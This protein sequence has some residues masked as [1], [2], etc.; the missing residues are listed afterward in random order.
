MA[1]DAVLLMALGGPGSMDEV[2]P[3]VESVLG[4]RP[5]PPHRIDE[6][7][8]HYEAVGGRS[9]L[10][11]WTRAQARALEDRL[12]VDG[13]TVPVVVGMRCWSPWLADTV[14]E[15]VA[16]RAKRVVTILMS[17]FRDAFT[18]GQYQASLARAA[19]EASA[20]D[21]VFQEV[22]GWHDHPLYTE[23]M[24]DRVN[25][26]AEVAQGID[27]AVTP[28][29]F[30][31]HS[32]PLNAPGVQ[33]HVAAVR[34]TAR[35]VAERLAWRRWQVVYQSRTG[36][37]DDPWLE[38]DVCSVIRDL[39]GQ[40]H[41]SVMIAC[42]GFVCDHVEVLYDLDIEAAGVARECGMTL[43]RAGTVGVHRKFIELLAGLVQ[44]AA[45][46]E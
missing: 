23:A 45:R 25:E 20:A 10:T 27:R 9:P 32:L 12:A 22:P 8:Q 41:R 36:R 19:Q 2:R 24:A 14:R 39:A 13:P 16:H 30:S 46:H 15:L 37:P 35:R 28:L 7:V 42:P 38:P 4:G 33:D 18:A 40:G 1:I 26:A 17:A 31:I 34:A 44:Q 3:F 29:L 5:V 21:I 6:V 11:E 43:A